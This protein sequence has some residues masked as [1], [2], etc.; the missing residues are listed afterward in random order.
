MA[1]PIDWVKRDVYKDGCIVKSAR[2]LGMAVEIYFNLCFTIGGYSVCPGLFPEN[3]KVVLDSLGERFL[4][5]HE[6]LRQ[7]AIEIGEAI[8]SRLID[9]DFSILHSNVPVMIKGVKVGEHDLICDILRRQGEAK[10]IAGR[11]SV[12]VKLRRI[13]KSNAK[14]HLQSLRPIL[15][16]ECW[17]RVQQRNKTYRPHWWQT[18]GHQPYWAGRLLILCELPEDE[19]KLYPFKLRA[20]K[21]VVGADW[22][23]LFGWSGH[24]VAIPK[25]APA[26]KQAPAPKAFAKARPAPSKPSWASFKKL[27][28]WKKYR[29]QQVAGVKQFLIKAGKSSSNSRKTIKSWEKDAKFKGRL[30]GQW[31]YDVDRRLFECGGVR[32]GGGSLM[33]AA[34]EQA[35]ETVYETY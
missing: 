12:E 24:E 8:R 9:K 27:L 16:E 10:P 17:L 13:S 28:N 11:F 32:P 2:V 26:P 21:R 3:I 5:L 18:I 31:Y 33:P 30:R 20:D 29:G 22:Q 6:F 4:I 25:R 35:L 15:Q 19:E 1:A 7:P 23:Q 34:T 14:K